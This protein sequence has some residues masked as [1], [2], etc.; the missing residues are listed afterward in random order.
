[1]NIL[2]LLVEGLA[3]VILPLTKIYQEVVVLA[4]LE[5]ELGLQ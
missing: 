4:D 5:Q 2:L 1:L 3:E